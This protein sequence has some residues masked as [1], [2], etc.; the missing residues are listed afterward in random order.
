MSEYINLVAFE[1]ISEMFRCLVD[2]KLA[3]TEY[4]LIILR[5]LLFFNSLLKKLTDPS[6]VLSVLIKLYDETINKWYF[7]I[8]INLYLLL[9]LLFLYGTLPQDLGKL[10]FVNQ[11]LTRTDYHRYN[12]LTLVSH[13]E[14]TLKKSFR[15]LFL[16]A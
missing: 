5:K 8:I 15:N 13:N 16:L 11:N 2:Q 7:L 14:G 6:T 4:R 9:Y 12:A 3:W 1:N 10:Y